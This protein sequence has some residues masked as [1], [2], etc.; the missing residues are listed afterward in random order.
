MKP[1][2][3]VAEVIHKFEKSFLDKHP[4]N[5]QILKTLNAIKNCRT[6]ALGGHVSHCNKCNHQHNSY[7]SCRNR[8]CPKCQASKREK[9]ILSREKE[10]LDVA[11]F[12]V[13]FTLPHE[14]NTLAMHQAKEVYN[15]LFRASWQ[16]IQTFASDPK[17]LGAKTGM[18]SVLHTWGQ[19]LSLHPHLHCIIPGGGITPQ[20]KWKLPRKSKGA[21]HSKYLFPKRALSSVFRAKFMT[22]LRKEVAIPQDIAAKVM[23]KDWVVYAKRPFIGPKQVI[24]YLGRY[25]HKIAISNHRLIDVNEKEVKFKYKNYKTQTYQNEMSLRGEEFLRRFA[26]HILPFGFVRMRHNGILAS[27]NKK[28]DLN[29]AK[30]FF[31]MKPWI[32]EEIPTEILL[33]KL[34]FN[35]VQC[36]KCKQNTLKISSSIL[37]ERGPPIYKKY[38]TPNLKFY[39]N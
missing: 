14:F 11:Y 38:L 5:H 6:S 15:A 36:P 24:E 34:N 8:H 3:E 28:V 33:H 2:Y 10:L 26:Q 19:N 20:G 13:V 17:H 35:P 25:T 31:K 39:H 18:T 12:H 23:R 1:S 22:E 32:Y 9:W 21:R 29:I 4:V 27:R 37:P 7:N 30:D 16:T